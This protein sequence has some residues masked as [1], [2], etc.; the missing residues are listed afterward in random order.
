MTCYD[1]D[2][3]SIILNK[4]HIA[5]RGSRDDLVNNADGSVD[6]EVKRNLRHHCRSVQPSIC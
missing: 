4:E 1:V 5:V 6:L 3:R 2:T